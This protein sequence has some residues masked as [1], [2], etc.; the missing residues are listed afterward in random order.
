M[1]A[2]DVHPGLI[3]IA[4][5]DDERCRYSVNTDRINERRLRRLPEGLLDQPFYGWVGG[6]ALLRSPLQRAYQTVSARKI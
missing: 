2:I 4:P 5:I 6:G 1:K 3:A